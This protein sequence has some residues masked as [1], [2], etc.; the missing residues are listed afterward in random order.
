MNTVRVKVMGRSI[1]LLVTS[2]LT[3]SCTWG[4]NTTVSF[5]EPGAPLKS[6]LAYISRSTGESLTCSASLANDIVIVRFKNA[7]LDD[8]KA[9]LAL[10]MCAQWQSSSDGRLTLVRTPILARNAAAEA[11]SQR[12]KLLKA[13]IQKEI[14][15][16]SKAKPIDDRM[17]EEMIRDTV[18]MFR[19]NSETNAWQRL[20]EIKRRLPQAGALFRVLQ[21]CNISALAAL[22]PGQRIVFSTKP[23]SV[24]RPI[25]PAVMNE[26]KQIAAQQA[27]W[28]KRARAMI[29]NGDQEDYVSYIFPWTQ[30][31]EADR[32]LLI[33]KRELFNGIRVEMRVADTNGRYI[34]R[35]DETIEEIDSS[36][37]QDLMEPGAPS[38]QEK[39]LELTGLAKEFAD[40]FR[41]RMRSGGLN[42]G[43]PESVRNALASPDKFEPMSY[44]FGGLAVALAERLDV[45]LVVETSDDMLFLGM[46]SGSERLTPNRL[47]AILRRCPLGPL[48]MEESPGWL[49]IRPLDLGAIEGSRTP[50]SLVQPLA[51]QLAHGSE[52]RLEEWAA[53]AAKIDCEGEAPPLLMIISMI[54]DNRESVGLSNW[55]QLRFYG[56]L[57]INQRRTLLAGNALQFGF[58]SPEQKA[59]LTKIIFNDPELESRRP[60]I[61]SS[62]LRGD[63]LP[64]LDGLD[65]EVTQV[66][67]GGIPAAAPIRLNQQDEAGFFVDAR[68]GEGHSTSMFMSL[69]SVA[70]NIFMGE[71][72]NDSESMWR[73][74]I[75]ALQPASS[76]NL[77]FSVMLAPEVVQEW[78]LRDQKRDPGSKKGKLEELPSSIRAE[79]Q[80]LLEEYRKSRIPPSDPPKR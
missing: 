8:V 55:Q 6:V 79:L 1:L 27:D 66:A 63:E 16:F 38:G 43:L 47:L 51:R 60:P 57:D 65:S 64:S 2:A 31:G 42:Q 3:V 34:M 33:C 39:P 4:Q 22:R 71:I 62:E 72:P 17:L 78:T 48:V 76:S 67:S 7:P 52:I 36:E 32:L 18:A 12:E 70:W 41:K 74:T 15:R 61:Q 9:K 37:F 50:R 35:S 5:T 75:E 11:L 28:S 20:E 25:P 77:Q 56:Q 80:K 13:D 40:E 19:S 44:T 14:D 73:M 53:T 58:L 49:T 24:Q 46:F 30:S 29:P 10:A 68:F 54:G 45:N 59:T 26:I 69:R 21:S 23:T